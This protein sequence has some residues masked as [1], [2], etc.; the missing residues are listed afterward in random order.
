VLLW[1]RS[2]RASVG[3]ECDGCSRPV[4]ERRAPSRPAVN[5]ASAHYSLFTDAGSGHITPN[6]HVW[7]VD[8]INGDNQHATSDLR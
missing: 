4:Q 1:L 7:H 8:V 6:E 5:R 3:D 2:G